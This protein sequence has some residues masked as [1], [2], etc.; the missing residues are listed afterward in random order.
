MQR[1]NDQVYGPGG[2]GGYGGDG[3]NGGWILARPGNGGRQQRMTASAST[4][5]STIA[6]LALTA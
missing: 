3:G 4:P 6:A 1:L 5:A 2:K